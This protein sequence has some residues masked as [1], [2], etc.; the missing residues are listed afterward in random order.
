[1]QKDYLQ[2]GLEP[3]RGNYRPV[4]WCFINCKSRSLCYPSAVLCRI[5]LNFSSDNDYWLGCAFKQA[6]LQKLGLGTCC[7]NFR[8]GLFLSAALES[9]YHRFGRHYFSIRY[10]HN[11]GHCSNYYF[12]EVKTIEQK[13]RLI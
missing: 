2:L 12:I 3:G 7:R 6:G 11:V 8:F 4:N 13:S 9:G 1:K 10:F 5:C